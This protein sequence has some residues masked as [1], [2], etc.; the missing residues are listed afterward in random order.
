MRTGE[1]EALNADEIRRALTTD[2]NDRLAVIRVFAEIDSTNNWLLQQPPPAAERFDVAVADYQTGGRGRHGRRWVLPPGAGICLSVAWTLELDPGEVAPLTLVLGVAALEA[3]QNLGARNIE[4]KWPN[5]L[6]YADG[7]LGGILVELATPR[8]N[9]CVVVA[10]IG[11]NW[12]LPPGFAETL[13]DMGQLRPTDLACVVGTRKLPAR[14][15][16]IAALI[17]EFVSA[18]H[19][20]LRRGFEDYHARWEAADYLR[21]RRVELVQ[22]KERLTGIARGISSSGELLLATGSRQHPSIESVAS[23]TVVSFDT[24]HGGAIDL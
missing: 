1:R 12:A 21:D 2:A 3:L 18:C 15:Q 19:N 20:F 4:L 22:G 24:T 9:S 6:V 17:G 5:D 8:T 7:K 11:I 16:L 23:G 10:G 13:A 14:N